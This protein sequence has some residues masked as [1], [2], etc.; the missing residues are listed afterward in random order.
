MIEAAE[1][2]S[3][4]RLAS[5]MLPIGGYSY[6]Q[7][8]E[9]AIE[10]HGITTEAAIQDWI[11]SLLTSSLARYELPLL[12][13]M[14][15]QVE[16]NALDALCVSN[17]LWLASRE[18]SELRAESLQMGHSLMRLLKGLEDTVL[19]RSNFR[20]ELQKFLP[21]QTHVSLPMAWA[22]TC[23]TWGIGNEA[24]LHTYAWT[25]LENQIA[26]AIKAVPLGQQAGQRL[27]S[28]L[29][30]LLLDA[31]VIAQ[32]LPDHERSNFAPGFVLASSQHEHQY[33]RIF[34]S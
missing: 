5:P 28:E 8:L 18:T 25:W 22:L 23:V 9:T 29:Q 21:S 7:G 17:T 26:A 34:R 3:A 11:G 2:L 10:T 33:S 20:N 4:M 24:C 6:S 32:T 1:L 14:H 19:A 13:Q 27:I 16:L 30:P 15:S 12:K 31:C